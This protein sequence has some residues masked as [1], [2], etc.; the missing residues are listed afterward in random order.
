MGERDETRAGPRLTL[1]RG[2]AEGVE[3][4]TADAAAALSALA[5]S[6]S[7]DDAVLRLAVVTLGG[8]LARRVEA[9]QRATQ[10]H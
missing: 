9:Q 5:A 2:G 8:S 10:G 4:K 1:L 7:D 3:E 6:L